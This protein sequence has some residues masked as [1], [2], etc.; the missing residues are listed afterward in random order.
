MVPWREIDTLSEEKEPIN[1]AF[2]DAFA[3]IRL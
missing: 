2:A 1:T 3:K